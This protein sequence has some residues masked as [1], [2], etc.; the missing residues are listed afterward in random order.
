MFPLLALSAV[1]W[2][3]AA[4]AE[5]P[6]ASSFQADGVTTVAVRAPNGTVMVEARPGLT[7]VEV[8]VTRMEWSEGCTVDSK[9]VGARVEVTIAKSESRV[10][11][12]CSADVRI[13]LPPQ[14][15][16][17]LEST[18]GEITVGGVAGG[19]R[20]SMGIG[21]VRL[22]DVSG[23]LEVNGNGGDLV[24]SYT[25]DA[26][27]SRWTSGEIRLTGLAG[28]AD[29]EVGVGRLDLSWSRLPAAGEIRLDV[30]G[31]GLVARFPEGSQLA[32]DLDATL[33]KVRSDLPSTDTAPVRLRART[34]AGSLKVL[35][36]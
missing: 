16:I 3:V 8:A 14:L 6:L 32:Q 9:V 5:P 17:D 10:A 2:S 23:A 36:N 28:T 11:Q 7:T 20:I 13:G 33:G 27:R 18:T 24:G 4:R 1:T 21:D 30:G 19:G 26:L 35:T 34:Q 29:V 12:V 15:A 22:A 25:G 31:G